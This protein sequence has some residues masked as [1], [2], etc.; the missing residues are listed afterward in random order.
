MVVMKVKMSNATGAVQ[1]GM[2]LCKMFSGIENASRQTVV[3]PVEALLSAA[4]VGVIQKN[5]D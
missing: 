4:R 2:L 1:R 3:S 5:H